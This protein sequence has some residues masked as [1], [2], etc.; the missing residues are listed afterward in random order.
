MKRAL[1]RKIWYRIGDAKA[2][3]LGDARDAALV[4]LAK[5]AKEID[6]NAVLREAR[7]KAVQERAAAEREAQAPTVAELVER[8]ISVRR[9]APRTASEYR[10]TLVKDIAPSALGAMK[11]KDA[12][13][14]DV[15]L[16][17]KRLADHKKHQADRAFL[18]VRFAYRWAMGEE[19]AP[20]VMLVDRNPTT[21][22]D[23]P[24]LSSERERRRTLISVRASKD[25]EAFAEVR[26]FWLGTASMRPVP[27]SFVR[28]LL[29]LG[30]RRTEASLATWNDIRLDGETPSWHIPAEHRKV[31]LTRRDPERDSLDVPLCPLAVRILSELR[32]ITG[33]AGAVFPHLHFASVGETM[34]RRTGIPDLALH[35]L[36]RSCAS[37]ILRLGGPPHVLVDVLGHRQRGLADS[38]LV[39]LQGR[40]VEEQRAWL[41]R[42]AEKIDSLGGSSGDPGSVVMFRGRRASAP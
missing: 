31:R 16:F 35:D 27:R 13:Q 1:G 10:R 15:R 11:A 38:D 28:L 19:I 34:R 6:P 2:L 29:L 5:L 17:V 30:L 4:A 8:Y 21:G 12:L 33:R 7:E 22:V 37:G 23:R 24:T 20:R 25:E 41:R 18:L 14:A 32:E 9:L 39:Y 36:R 40:R 26:T 3:N 42:W